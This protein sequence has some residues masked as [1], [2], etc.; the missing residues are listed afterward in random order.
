MRF[1]FS[2]PQSANE[3]K[4]NSATAATSLGRGYPPLPKPLPPTPPPPPRAGISEADPF[5]TA[6]EQRLMDEAILG[7]PL[8]L[9]QM[10]PHPAVRGW[11]QAP[12]SRNTVVDI[13][14]SLVIYK[15]HWWQHTSAVAERYREIAASVKQRIAKAMAEARTRMLVERPLALVELHDLIIPPPERQKIYLGVDLATPEF[16]IKK[17]RRKTARARG[18]K[19]VSR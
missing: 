8:V 16:T 6:E 13:S 4:N 10:S 18:I 7:I 5:M 11:Y 12:I 2:K 1:W 19:P 3:E 15:A 14:D 9:W 17:P